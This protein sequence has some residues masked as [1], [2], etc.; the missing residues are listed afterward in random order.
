MEK[1]VVLLTSH[2]TCQGETTNQAMSEQFICTDSHQVHKPYQTLQIIASSRLQKKRLSNFTNVVQTIYLK[3][4][5]LLIIFSLI[6]LYADN[7]F[8]QNGNPPVEK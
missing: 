2:C 5:F 1:A 3:E 4:I 8:Y 7:L 6:F